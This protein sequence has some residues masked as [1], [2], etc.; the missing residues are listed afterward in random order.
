MYRSSGIDKIN[1]VIFFFFFFRL[2]GYT[3]F[4]A[5]REIVQNSGEA[6][7]VPESSLFLFIAIVHK[8]PKL[9]STINTAPGL[10]FSGLC[11]T[12]LVIDYFKYY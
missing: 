3:K 6:Q 5:N 4:F 10:I 7:K 2:G 1:S 8:S 12:R 11:Q 9:V